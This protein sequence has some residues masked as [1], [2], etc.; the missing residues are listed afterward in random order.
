MKQQVLIVGI[1]GMMGGKIAK[2]ILERG[3]HGVRALVR[4]KVAKAKELAPYVA[5]GVELVEGDVVSGTGLDAA[6]D[7]AAAVVSALNNEEGLIVEGQTN[8]L[9][10]AERNGVQRFLPSDFSVDYRKLEMGD[11]FNLDMRK[12][13]LPRLLDSKVAHTLV[14]N[15]AFAEVLPEGFLGFLDLAG[16][17]VN[18]WGDPNQKMDV[19][20]TDDVAQYVAAAVLDPRMANAALRI[21]GD[22]ISSREIAE[23]LAGFTLREMGSAGELKARIAAKK[24]SSPN[25]WAY[26][27]DQYLWSMQSGAGKLDALDNSLY[28]EIRP[29]SAVDYLRGRLGA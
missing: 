20:V 22:V 13:F 21:A 25:A 8:L 6:T 26:L 9:Q 23:G 16:K 29:M 11:N 15:G 10:A 17:A 3:E 14:M 19:T 1:T 18:A 2:A 27:G 4:D 28:P 7:G 24:E 5:Q 12:K